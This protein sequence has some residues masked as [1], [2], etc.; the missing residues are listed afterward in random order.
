MQLVVIDYGLGNLASVGNAL[1]KLG[2]PFVV[3]SKPA[4]LAAATAIILPGV[5][6]AGAGMQGLRERGLDEAI[7][8][9]A[10]NSTPILGICLGMQLL[11]RSS[12][13]GHLECLG[14][15][16]GTVKKFNTSLKVPQ[17]GWNQVDATANTKL[18]KDVTNNSYFYFV[19]SYYCAPDDTQIATGLTDYDGRFCSVYEE[20]MIAGVQFHPEK[21]GDAGLQVLR[22]FWEAAC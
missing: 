14:L 18:L 3:S 15:I 7:L 19:H 2:I 5:G 4:E 10:K 11:M 20:S 1:K 13:E 17:M 21:S 22:N 9:A 6:A 16:P 8:S 12:E